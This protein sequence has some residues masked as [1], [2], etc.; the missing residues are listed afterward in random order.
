MFS[1]SF[2]KPITDKNSEKYGVQ[3][4]NIENHYCV[5]SIIWKNNV[6]STMYFPEKGFNVINPET[7]QNLGFIS[8]ED[9]IFILKEYSLK[10]NKEDFS[11]ILFAKKKNNFE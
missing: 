11:W 2:K 8:A 4:V 9:A 1:M 5:I 3:E 10:Y 7:N 6:K